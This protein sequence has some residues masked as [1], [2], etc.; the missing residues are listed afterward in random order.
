MER[1]YSKRYR[2]TFPSDNAHEFARGLSSFTCGRKSTLKPTAVPSV[3][4]W[5]KRSPVKREAVQ[6]RGKRPQ[7]RKLRRLI[8][9]RVTP[10]AKYLWSHRKLRFSRHSQKIWK[11]LQLMIHKVSFM[12]FKL[13]VNG[14]IK[15]STKSQVKKKIKSEVEELIDTLN[16]RTRGKSIHNR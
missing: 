14:Y 7:K 11:I 5:K 6:S 8:Y 9:Q 15:K 12:T 1:R 10:R 3:F 2:Q 4:H 13:K 16:Q